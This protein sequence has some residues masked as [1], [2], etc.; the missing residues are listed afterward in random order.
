MPEFHKLTLSDDVQLIVATAADYRRMMRNEYVMPEHIV[1]ALIDDDVFYTT[2]SMNGI[3]I[4]DLRKHIEQYL[5]SLDHVPEDFNFSND[6]ISMQY[7]AMMVIACKLAFS[8]SDGVDNPHIDLPMLF[9]AVC[10]LKDSWASYYLRDAIGAVD[11]DTLAD[12]LNKLIENT[13]IASPDSDDFFTER[14]EDYDDEDSDEEQSPRVK[15]WKQYVTCVNDNVDSHNP[16]IGRE[17]E[18]DRTVQVLC[19]KDKNNPLHVGE[20]GVGKTALV[21]GLADRINRGDVPERL[22]G[23]HIYMLDMGTLVAGTQ[24]RGDFEKRLKVIMEGAAKEGNAIIYI[25]EIHTL[26]GA[27]AGGDSSLDASNML[28]PY[29]ENG[30]IRF[31]GS[32]TY[33][34]FNR[35][36]AKSKSLVRRFQQIDI[37]EPSVDETLLIVKGLQKKYETFHHVTYRA[38]ALEWIVRATAKYISDRCLPD[39]AID[40]M[41]EAGAYLE[42]HPNNRKRQ[43]VTTALVTKLIERTAKI[44]ASVLREDGKASLGTLK[45]RILARVFGQDE[46]VANVVEAIETAKAGLQD[47]DKPLASLL[48][49][50]PTGVGKTELA[51]VLADEMGASLVRFDMSE[52]MDKESVNKLIGSPSGYVGYEDGGQLVD[53]IR[54]TPNCVLLLD[55]IEK[56]HADVYNILLQIMDYARLTDN[57]GKKADFRNV[58]LIMTSN[59]GAQ[60]ASRANVGFQGHTSR[61]EAMLSQVKRTF[62]PEFLNRLSSVVVFH[63]MDENMA[64]RIM[65][66][67]LKVLAGKLA[68]KKVS[69]KLSPEAEAL[70]LKEGF[71]PEYGAREMD[72][73]ISRK[74]K[75]LLVHEILYGRLRDGGN[76]SVGVKSGSLSVEV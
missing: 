70:I 25:D 17:R 73:V 28:K 30:T 75:R 29:L 42:M 12:F 55:E 43:Y 35:Y 56:A 38:D 24:Y 23:S 4:G 31:I 53:A 67:K 47:D 65:H 58:V 5:N 18:L 15:S 57:H 63:D 50:G 8:T 69:L 45:S 54:K 3:R 1:L 66:K 2:C 49:V 32:T 33:E 14:L 36:F 9:M 46:A 11:E 62:K 19:R 26:V 72:R 61:G 6:S 48:F 13:E 52:Y 16:L 34:E 10:Q 44:D 64:T 60:F 22:R 68:G 51:R 7:K 20:A 59:A 27:G 74:L 71:S 37:A 39:K 40:L 41:D 76:A 21:Y